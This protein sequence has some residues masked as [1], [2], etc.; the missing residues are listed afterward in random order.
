MYIGSRI[1]LPTALSDH[2]ARK[3]SPENDLR[4]Q[5]G[6][7][8]DDPGQA[9]DGVLPDAPEE[10]LLHDGVRSNEQLAQHQAHAQEVQRRLLAQPNTRR[11]NL[12][13]LST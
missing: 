5:V 11:R 13:Q 6:R 2:I 3:S 7:P 4:R 8:R 12:T 10:G 9:E 1:S